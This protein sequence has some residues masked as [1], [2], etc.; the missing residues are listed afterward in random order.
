[1][2]QH[3]IVWLA[4]CG[5]ILA[6][7]CALACAIACAWLARPERRERPAAQPSVQPVALVYV[8]PP[9]PPPIYLVAPSRATAQHRPD[10]A[11]ATQRDGVVLDGRY[12]G[13]G[14]VL[15]GWLQ[16]EPDA[17]E[18]IRIACDLGRVGGADS[19]RALLDGVRTGVLSPTVAADNLT[20]GGFDAGIAVAGA[21]QDPE[22]RVRALASNLVGRSTPMR[23]T[24]ALA[25]GTSHPRPDRPPGRPVPPR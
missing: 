24:T 4:V 2:G 16:E 20:Q 13:L 5:G 1:M 3:L 23:R 9:A 25:L 17:V 18:R 12:P 10:V 19:A 6:A 15:G 7:A 22:P 8:P 14:R 21:L 11:T